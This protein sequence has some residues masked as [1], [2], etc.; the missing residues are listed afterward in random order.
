MLTFIHSYPTIQQCKSQEQQY[1]EQQRSE[2]EFEYIT[3]RCSIYHIIFH[4]II[5][6]LLKDQKHTL[7]DND[8]EHICKLTDGFSDADMH[9]LC[10][11][12]ALGRIRDIHDIELLLSEEVRG[13]SVDNF[14]KS[15]KAIRPSVSESDLKQYEDWNKTDGS[16]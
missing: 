15:L 10:H 1:I 6:N 5:S 16:I 14:I 12:A 13:I 8:M 11:D 3:F 9:S 2:L 4:A 7:T